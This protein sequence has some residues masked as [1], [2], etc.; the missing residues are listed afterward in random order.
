MPLSSKCPLVIRRHDLVGVPGG[1]NEGAGKVVEGNVSAESRPEGCSHGLPLGEVSS[2]Y[3]PE[4]R[5]PAGGTETQQQD[6]CWL[7]AARDVVLTQSLPEA[8]VLC[9]LLPRRRTGS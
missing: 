2:F 9:L 5:C 3:P 4:P 8:L 6:R 7:M 1:E